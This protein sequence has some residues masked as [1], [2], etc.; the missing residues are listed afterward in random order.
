MRLHLAVHVGDPGACGNGRRAL[1]GVD[2]HIPQRGHVDHHAAIA[3][4]KPR[5]AVTAAAHGEQQLTFTRESD[6]GR[7]VGSVRA[8]RD[9]GGTLVDHGVPY[10]TRLFVL[11]MRRQDE[12]A[13]H[14]P[15]EF[16]QRR[17]LEDGGSAGKPDRGNVGGGSG[18]RADGI[19][20]RQRRAAGERGI[21]EVSSFHFSAPR[22]MVRS[23]V[24]RQQ[25]RTTFERHR[26][27]LTRFL[28]TLQDPARAPPGDDLHR[29]HH[30]RRGV[31]RQQH[32]DLRPS[33][34]PWC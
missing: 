14:A 34:Q 17:L 13:T 27:F 23:V 28:E 25:E 29:R 7:N 3:G 21:D 32:G 5:E 8:A 19:R 9:D 24:T 20:Q 33:D 12:R 15:G 6:R 4:G 2:A 1:A 22:R 26:R 31:R 30:R 10:T 18:S 11:G 16:G